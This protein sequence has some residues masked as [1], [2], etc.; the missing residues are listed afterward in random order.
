MSSN[1]CFV[2]SA[3]DHRENLLA[4][5]QSDLF[6]TFS[7]FISSGKVV[8]FLY[9]YINFSGRKVYKQTGS[10]YVSVFFDCCSQV[11][12]CIGFFDFWSEQRMPSQI[13]KI[14]FCI[15]LL[16][17]LQNF[18]LRSKLKT[19][20]ISWNQPRSKGHLSLFHS[21]RG[22]II[23]TQDTLGTRLKL[24]QARPQMIGKSC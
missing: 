7:V 23:K 19:W 12:H 6:H 20:L 10:V 3:L 17:G 22:R 5:T 16:S 11:T 4:L 15:L 24:T 9:C 1:T 18:F 13:E 21:A 14:L 2:R 8:V